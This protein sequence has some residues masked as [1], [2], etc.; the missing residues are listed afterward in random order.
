MTVPDQ[1]GPLTALPVRVRPRHGETASSYLARLAHANHLRP[2]YLRSV[3]GR[4][5]QPGTIRADRLAAISGRPADALRHTL[6][7]LDRRPGGGPPQLMRTRSPAA[8]NPVISDR[9]RRDAAADAAVPIS[10]LA[11]RHHLP[12]RTVLAA[13][14]PPDWAHGA[15][16]PKW[17]GP[18]LAPLRGLIDTWLTEEPALSARKIWERLL[19]E[20]NADIS[21][22]TVT[23][24]VTRQRARSDDETNDTT[25]RSPRLPS[26]SKQ[27]LLGR[28]KRAPRGN[29][30]PLQSHDSRLTPVKPKGA[31]Q[32]QCLGGMILL[33]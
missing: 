33:S 10:V 28:R 14:T 8:G 9:F 23:A 19:D 22:V 13:L 24:Y 15:P 25:H 12:R 27:A 1:P 6:A 20:H 26:T 5:S 4:P 3:I 21:H 29:G 16:F 7:G 17:Q 11:A 31:G 30:N 2:S 18:V 32:D